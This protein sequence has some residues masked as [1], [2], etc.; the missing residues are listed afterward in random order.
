MKIFIHWVGLFMLIATI[1]AMCG[2][3]TYGGVHHQISCSC[4]K[5][6]GIQ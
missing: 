5:G 6:V 4:S 3:V 2:G 1:C